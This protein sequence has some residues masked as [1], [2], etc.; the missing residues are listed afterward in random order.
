VQQGVGTGVNALNDTLDL[1]SGLKPAPLPILM[2][3]RYTITVEPSP[4]PP[5]AL[6]GASVF[7]SGAIR[8]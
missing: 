5:G 8:P 7:D 2:S 4:P 6:G 3:G 1:G